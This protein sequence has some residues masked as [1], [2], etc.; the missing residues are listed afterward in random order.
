MAVSTVGSRVAL[1]C[2]EQDD[3][4][5]RWSLEAQKPQL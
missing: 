2:V 5:P 1:E 4:P 3:S